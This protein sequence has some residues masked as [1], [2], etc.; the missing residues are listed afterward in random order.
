MFQF[1]HRPIRIIDEKNGRNF[2]ERF[3]TG[4]QTIWE[5]TQDKIGELGDINDPAK[6]REDLLQFL[7]DHVGFTQ[8][9]NNITQD[10]EENDL[11]KLIALAVALWKQKGIEPGYENIVRLF[12]GKSVRI[13]NF[14]D[15]RLIIG[16]S[17]FGEEQLGED[18]WFISVPGVERQEDV[19]NDVVDLLSFEGKSK[20]SSF[21]RNPV[22]E[23][24]PA[25]GLN[26][27][28][29]PGS[30]FPAGSEKHIK[31]SGGFLR[32]SAIAAYNFVA[33]FTIEMF[34]RTT[35]TKAS[36]TLF[37]QIDSGGVGIRID[38]DSSANTVSYSISDG[39]TTISDS[40]TPL[41]DLDDGSNRHLALVLDRTNDAVRL[42]LNGS[43]STSASALGALGDPSNANK[44]VIGAEAPT[45]RLYE[46]DMDNFR[47]STNA[48]Y[49]VTSSTLAVP[50]SGFTEF[51]E[52][53]L[54]EFFTDIRIVDEGDLN[55]ILMQRILNLMRPISE[56]LNLIF[57]DFFDNFTAGAGRFVNLTGS[58]TVNT[59][60]Q[61]QLENDTIVATDVL[62]DTDFTDYVLQVK[63]Q[64][65][66]SAGGEFSVL[67]FLLDVDNFYEFRIDTAAA[68]VSLHKNVGGV[69]SQI[70][71]TTSFDLVP[72]T[73]YIFT[74]TTSFNSVT[75][76]TLIQTLVDANP[77]HKVFDASFEKGKFGMKTDSS[78]IMKIDEVEMFQ[79]P[80]DVQ[81]VLPGFDL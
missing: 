61:F 15:F 56:R 60:T 9:L 57:I 79:L 59:D 30:G 16:E 5:D 77:I 65:D 53:A 49:D 17:A 50:L 69:S 37:H 67:F 80:L 35:I 43:E 55:K 1:I 27:F 38:F 19:A 21:F 51:I 70:G 33:D 76:T 48:V 25:L 32:Q 4:P 75:N 18:S 29:N 22:E 10:L 52:E 26:F 6:T 54:D 41:A 74:I 68:E 2:V 78:T 11:R 23:V 28:N 66:D 46:G 13:F 42:Y 40:L 62:N 72:E 31:F 45:L 44:L 7:K 36:Q 34:I 3:L 12:T 8:E 39:V 20:D 58:A 73:S 64:D 63:A 71:A 14:F 24:N 47:I 81:Q